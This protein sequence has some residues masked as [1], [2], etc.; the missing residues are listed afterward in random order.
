R[1]FSTGRQRRSRVRYPVNDEIERPGKA[2]AIRPG[3]AALR[4]LPQITTNCR[5]SHISSA[6][7]NVSGSCVSSSR[8]HP[9][10]SRKPTLKDRHGGPCGKRNYVGA[11]RPLR[12]LVDSW[13]Y[14]PR[15]NQ[16]KAKHRELASFE[17][18]RQF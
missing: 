7:V 11:R 16:R 4:Y 15:L 1:W 12:M 6:K 5:H 3:A 14:L 8:Q 17:V 10:N 13:P 9:A 2:R 18:N